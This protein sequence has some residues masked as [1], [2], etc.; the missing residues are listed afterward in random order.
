MAISRRQ[1]NE[2]LRSDMWRAC[3]ILRR[4][5]NVGGVIFT[6]DG[7]ALSGKLT[8]DSHL[9][10]LTVGSGI[11]ADRI[12]VINGNS[13][14][15][16]YAASACPALAGVTHALNGGG[17]LTPAGR[18][19]ER[20]LSAHTVTSLSRRGPSNRTRITIAQS[21][22]SGQPRKVLSLRAPAP[23][24]RSASA[25]RSWSRRCTC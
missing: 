23:R 13:H 12:T 1:T 2:T 24:S 5:N 4:D 8:A 7:Q 15:V 6:A 18:Q 11:S 21:T 20:Q 22:F 25:R 10:C 19:H 3:D 16:Y 9:T 14:T 17:A